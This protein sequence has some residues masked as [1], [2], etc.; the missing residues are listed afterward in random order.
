MT[1]GSLICLFF[2]S[3]FKMLYT[4]GLLVM[5]SVS[6]SQGEYPLEGSHFHS[7]GSSFALGPLNCATA[8]DEFVH[9]IAIA[10]CEPFLLPS[11]HL[12]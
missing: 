7:C 2:F 11:R 3:L 9:E 1:F 5:L 4:C 6:Q 10:S 8:N 12:T